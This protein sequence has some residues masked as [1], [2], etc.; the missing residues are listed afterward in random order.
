MQVM[1][2]LASKETDLIMKAERIQHLEQLL[3]AKDRAIS[4][5]DRQI[6]EMGLQLELTR[7][8]NRQDADGNDDEVRRL[9]DLVRELGTANAAQGRKIKA[10][11]QGGGSQQIL[12]EE[13]PVA[14]HN[15]R[16]GDL[17]HQAPVPPPP[18]ESQPVQLVSRAAVRAELDSRPSVPSV[19]SMGPNSTVTFQVT[20]AAGEQK[21]WV[22]LSKDDKIDVSALQPLHWFECSEQKERGQKR[23]TRQ[24]LVF[25]TGLALMNG[26][27][28]KWYRPHLLLNR[29]L[30]GDE[31]A[32][33]L[34]LQFSAG[35]VDGFTTDTK[36]SVRLLV[37]NRE[38][39]S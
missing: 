1:S 3:T 20:T 7:Q 39:V 5:K 25:S 9:T 22:D 34:V 35:A 2:Q 14:L 30:V 10:L 6:S 12:P 28:F 38:Q 36:I 31:E 18:V 23:L 17:Y 21:Q 24:L 4:D 16:D 19:P 32:Q 29:M 33:L 13:A 27:K 8:G 15:H 37:E 11:S 26:A